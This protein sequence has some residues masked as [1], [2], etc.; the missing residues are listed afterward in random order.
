[1]LGPSHR[2]RHA[3]PY[4]TLVAAFSI[5]LS[6]SLRLIKRVLAGLNKTAIG[7]CDT[8]LALRVPLP[9]HR[10]GLVCVFVPLLAWLRQHLCLVCS[11]AFAATAGKTPLLPDVSTACVATQLP[12]PCGLPGTR[13]STTTG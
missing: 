4:L 5:S 2:E 1:M 3:P 8:A 9:V 6:L 7:W 12:L 10:L 11:T 13:C